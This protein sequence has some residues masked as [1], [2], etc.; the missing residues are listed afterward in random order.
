LQ[1]IA[2]RFRENIEGTTPKAPICNAPWVSAV[3]EVDGNVRPCFFHPSVGNI[4]QLSL[5]EAI[6]SETALSFRSN[7]KIA[8]NPTCQRCVCSL[9]YSE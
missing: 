5:E 4:N 8:S 1:R 9:N 7:L 3:I 6:N 2:R